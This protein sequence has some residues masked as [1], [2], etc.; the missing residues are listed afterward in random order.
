M[1]IPDFKHPPAGFAWR[2]PHFQPSELADPYTRLLIVVPA[3][4][5]WLEE[6]R[7]ELDEPMIIND[8][9]RTPARQVKH[10]GR[11]T[12][13]HVDGMAVDVWCYGERADK[14]EKIAI[15]KGVLGRGIYQNSRT[16]I[17]K[18]FLH[19][20]IWTKAPE[21]LRPRLWSG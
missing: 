21:G 7:I 16:A 9:T 11:P 1:R 3:F 12:G 17:R 13:S 14:L 2:W 4:L 10:S 15:A 20:D 8:G 6:V 18:R 5:N 19:L